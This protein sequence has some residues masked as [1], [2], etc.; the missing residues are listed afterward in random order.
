VVAPAE[1]A[2]FHQSTHA[3]FS[4]NDPSFPAHVFF[5]GHTSTGDTYALETTGE[6]AGADS[7]VV[8][9]DHETGEVA[10]RWEGVADFLDWMINAPPP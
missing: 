6:R 5:F 7:N 2:E 10:K 1:L 8:M 3:H 9:I 4:Q